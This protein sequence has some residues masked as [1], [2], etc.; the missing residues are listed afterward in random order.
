MPTNVRSEN[1]RGGITAHTVNITTAEQAVERRKPWK[2]L[3]IAVATSVSLAAGVVAVLSYFG[4]NPPRLE[5]RP[6]P[7]LVNGPR[8]NP[9]KPTVLAQSR[10][11]AASPTTK[12]LTKMAESPKTI[13]VTS[14]NQSGGITANTVNIGQQPRVLTPVLEQETLGVIQGYKKVDVICIWGDQDGFRLATEIADFLRA[15]GIEVNGV[16]QAMFTRPVIG[17]HAEPA[18]DTLKL[19]I[20]ANS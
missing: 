6:P 4:V 19:I 9:A 1:Q 15:K 2:V 3:A 20:G 10:T 8:Q 11:I 12:E 5:S 18:G 13:N 14:Y 7:A 17:L 16:N